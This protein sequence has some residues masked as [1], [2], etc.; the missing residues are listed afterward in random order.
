M[1]QTAK[2]FELGEISYAGKLGL[3]LAI[4][5]AL[6]L[7]LEAIRTR[8]NSL[9]KTL[10]TSLAEIAGCSVHDDGIVQSGIVTFNLADIDAANVSDYLAQLGIKAGAPPAFTSLVALTELTGRRCPPL[11]G[12]WKS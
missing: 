9:A 11:E 4:D 1:N 10:R 2:R 8:V 12:Y 7:G 3:G 5:Y 6:E